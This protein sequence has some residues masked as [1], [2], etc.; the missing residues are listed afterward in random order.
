MKRRN[1]RIYAVKLP[2]LKPIPVK[3]QTLLTREVLR[4]EQ[5]NWDGRKAWAE[6]SPLP[7]FHNESLAECLA[8]A[9]EFFTLSAFMSQELPVSLKTAVEILD[10]Q[11]ELPV[12]SSKVFTGD[13]ENSALLTV[14]ELHDFDC[15]LQSLDQARVCKVKVGSEGLRTSR[16]F[17]E[18]LL[19]TRRDR[20]LRVDCNQALETSSEVEVRALLEGLPIAYVEEP[21]DNLERLKAFARSFPLALDESLGLDTELDALAKAWVIKPNRLGF[22]KTLERFADAGPQVKILSNSFESLE[23][24]QTYVWAYR[25]I[26]KNPQACGLGTAFYM[27]DSALDGGWDPK[28]YRSAWPVAPVADCGHRGE[29]I[30]EN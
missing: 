10:W 7:G 3:R 5:D 13:F 23:T 18:A 16:L 28:V 30:W 26:V 1:T 12:P 19:A 21:F 27:A 25:N 15:T 11:M 2:L 17:L 6:C 22:H 9:I 20:E 4:I 14:P 24:L 8:A 29:L